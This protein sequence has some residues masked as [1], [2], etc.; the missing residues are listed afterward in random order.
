MGA[1]FNTTKTHG[2]GVGLAL[3]HATIER[4]RG[5]LSMH[6]ASGGGMAVRFEV[7]LHQESGEIDERLAG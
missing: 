7:P 4:L 6:E 5:T 2:L 3:S 1:L